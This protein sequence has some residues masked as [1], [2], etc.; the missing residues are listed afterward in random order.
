MSLALD[1]N[2]ASEG[3]YTAIGDLEHRAKYDRHLASVHQLADIMVS[4]ISEIA[5]Y[6]DVEFV[7]AVPPEPKKEF[8]LPSILAKLI[9]QKLDI[10]NVTDRF[11]WRGE[12]GKLKDAKIDEKW[13]RLESAGLEFVDDCI[14]GKTV[15]ILDDLYQSGRTMQFVGKQLID[16]GAKRIYGLAIVKSWR[17]TDNQ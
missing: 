9:A 7:S 10:T 3:K 1:F 16:V 15:L 12:K 13:D 17:L 8:D 11:V 5:Y 14:E 2:L 6:R 4:T